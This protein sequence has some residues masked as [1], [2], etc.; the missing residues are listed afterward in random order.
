MTLLVAGIVAVRVRS[1]KRAVV[2][3]IEELVTGIIVAFL[4][5]E[6]V[7][8]TIIVVE[9]VPPLLDEAIELEVVLTVIDEW[10]DDETLEAMLEELDRIDVDVEVLVVGAM[11]AIE[12]WWMSEN[13][14]CGSVMFYLRCC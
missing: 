1:V 11:A 8:V 10:I 13:T 7:E 6:G 14:R 3:G 2:I 5:E 9:F 4:E 12:L